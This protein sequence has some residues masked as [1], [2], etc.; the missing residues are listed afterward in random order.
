MNLLL[1]VGNTNVKWAWHDGSLHGFGDYAHEDAEIDDIVDTIAEADQD[2]TGIWIASVADD[3]FTEELGE[4][5]ADEF[6][7]EAVFVEVEEDAFDIR[8]A[9]SH[10]ERLGVDRWLAMIGARAGVGG[11]IIVADAGTTLTLDGLLDDGTHVGGMICPGMH[12]MQDA[13]LEDTAKVAEHAVDVSDH[14]ELFADDTSAAVISGSV[15]AAVA[16]IEYAAEELERISGEL[17]EVFLT[18]GGA[19]ALA[20]LMGLEVHVLRE[21]VLRGLALVVDAEGDLE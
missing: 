8:V 2:V 7:I 15:F 9:Y 18:G 6:D 3:E 13:V 14:I 1:D 12:L 11:P 19:T 17:P 16:L 4:S 20:P 10:P 5:L 21:L